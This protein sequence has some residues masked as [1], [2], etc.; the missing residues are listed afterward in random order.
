M[1]EINNFFLFGC[2]WLVPLGAVFCVI[3]FLWLHGRLV[4]GMRSSGTENLNL[5]EFMGG[6]RLVMMIYALF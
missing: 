6:P 4:G 5:S 1:L 2:L 3:H